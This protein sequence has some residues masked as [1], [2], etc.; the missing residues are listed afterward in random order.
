MLIIKY[1]TFFFVQLW[2]MVKTSQ[3]YL[4]DGHLTLIWQDAAFYYSYFLW[5]EDSHGSQLKP[6]EMP[7]SKSTV[8]MKP[9]IIPGILADE[10]YQYDFIYKRNTR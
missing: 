7:N 10:F 1:L 9:Q 6:K 3:S 4:Q 5:F 2:E 8:A